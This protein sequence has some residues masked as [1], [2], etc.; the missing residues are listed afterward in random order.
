MSQNTAPSVKLASRI[1]D[2]LQGYVREMTAEFSE[3]AE[4]ESA[5]GMGHRQQQA[6]ELLKAAPEEGL[7]TADIAQAMDGYD[8]PNAYLTLRSLV[9]RGLVELIPGS[10]PQRWRAIRDRGSSTPYL[11]AAQ[12]V[13]AGEWAT[14]GDVSIAIRGDDRAAR[15]VGRAAAKLPDFPSPHRI[16]GAGGTIPDGWRDHEGQGPEECQRRLEADGVTFTDARADP[17]RRL[18]WEVL[19]ERARALGVEVPPDP[20]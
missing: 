3:T 18:P 4:P 14:Y 6:Y 16:I 8:V 11:L 2:A 13:R 5:T 12:A 9:N 20:Q 7:K 17:M 15:A 10:S 19:R 1:A